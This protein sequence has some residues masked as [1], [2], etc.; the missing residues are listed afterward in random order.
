VQGRCEYQ[1]GRTEWVQ[2][3]GAAVARRER[4]EWDKGLDVCYGHEPQRCSVSPDTFSRRI[5]PSLQY[6]STRI[7]ITLFAPSKHRSYRGFLRDLCL[8]KI[9]WLSAKIRCGGVTSSR[10]DTRH[11]RQAPH[12]NHYTPTSLARS[13]TSPPSTQRTTSIGLLSC[14]YFINLHIMR[15]MQH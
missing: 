2:G 14:S 5:D 8:K 1:L 4:S 9:N 12:R 10:P 13:V 6:H 11:I 3:H 7:L 15:V